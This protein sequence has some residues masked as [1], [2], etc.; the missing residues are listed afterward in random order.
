MTGFSPRERV[1]SSWNALV[2]RER[3]TAEEAEQIKSAKSQRGVQMAVDV[4]RRVVAVGFYAD[5]AAA[6]LE[7]GSRQEDIWGLDWLPDSKQVLFDK[8]PLNIRP[9]AGNGSMTINDPH[10]RALV[11]EIVRAR[12]E[13]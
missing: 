1:A 4:L 9:N 13:S 12:L 7:D 5:C 2:I 3:P 6:L 8:S 10:V 11:E